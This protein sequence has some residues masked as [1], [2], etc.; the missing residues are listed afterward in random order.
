[1]FCVIVFGEAFGAPNTR[2]A[3][4]ALFLIFET[5]ANFSARSTRASSISLAACSAVN[6]ITSSSKESSTFDEGMKVEA[7]YRGK[8]KYYP[9]KISR[10][11][12]NGTYDINYDDGEKESP[13]VGGVS[14]KSI[15]SPPNIEGEPLDCMT[16]RIMS[17]FLFCV[18]EPK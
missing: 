2:G 13:T 10:V 1:M 14:S 15:L 9:G 4:C 3:S 11:R 17:N 18:G 6:S 8:E 12:A 16:M 7:R 5:E